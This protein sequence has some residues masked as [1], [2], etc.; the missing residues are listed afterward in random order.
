VEP[1]PV[2]AGIGEEARSP[3]TRKLPQLRVRLAVEK[4]GVDP[5]GELVRVSLAC[6]RSALMLTHQRHHLGH[7]HD[8][9]RRRQAEHEIEIRAKDQALVEA[10]N[11]IV[12]A[13]FDEER[14]D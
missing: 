14:D 10:A 2:N 3:C 1:Q 13:A 12:Q 6:R 11:L 8:I 5:R 9:R 7:R 4:L